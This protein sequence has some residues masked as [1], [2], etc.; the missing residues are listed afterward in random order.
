M[1]TWF[2][3]TIFVVSGLQDLMYDVGAYALS[4]YRRFVFGDRERLTTEK[5]R[6]REEQRL[7]VM[8]P[9]WNEG[10][11]V[12][13]MVANI[14]DRV[15]YRNYVIFVGT[16]PNDAA[17]QSA[18]DALAVKHKQLIKVVNPR[19]GPTCKA[20]CLN[21]VYETIK[22]YERMHG[23]NFDMIA[24]HDAEDVVHPYGF[25]LYNYLIP[26]VDAI[27]LPI[28]PLPTD[29][30][31]F[32]HWVYADEFCENH[33]KDVPVREKIS[34]F[35]PFAGVGT[36]FSRRVF[37]ALEQISG[38]EIFNEKSMAEDYSMSKKL[39]LMGLKTIFVNLV[40]ADDKSPWWTPLYK[41]PGF[42]SNWAFFPF[43]FTRSVR[44][45][46]RWIIGISL[47]EWEHS[48]WGP[49]PKMYES[50]VKDRKVFAAMSAS[51][52]GYFVL[53]YMLVA[54]ASYHGL[55]PFQLLPVVSPGSPVNYLLG[56]A[57]CIMTVR[58]IQ[59]W[60]IISRVYGVTAGTLSLV[61]I[62]VSNVI[63]GLAA[64]RALQAFARER[65]GKT[66]VKWDKTQHVE[67]VGSLPTDPAGMGE[68]KKVREELP[69]DRLLAMLKSGERRD[70][71]TALNSIPRNLPAQQRA[72][73][74]AEMTKLSDSDDTQVRATVA[75]SLGFVN[76]AESVSLMEHL[77]KDRQW[78]VRANSI[79]ALF[80]Q[81]NVMPQIER[82]LSSG[83]KFAIEVITRTVEQDRL[84]RAAVF[85]H[86]DAN[87][88]CAVFGSLIKESTILEWLYADWRVAGEKTPPLPTA[89][90]K[91][92]PPAADLPIDRKHAA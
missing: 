43:D 57:A 38:H 30:R 79:K 48:G 36:G 54:L 21:N 76:W 22:V 83:D 52:I 19:P 59:R 88:G 37:H 10:D 27:Q 26:R 3:A 71:L 51:F 23:V 42:I 44:Q 9:A 1:L 29:H 41:R 4:L 85:A 12:A 15:E 8:V 75:K 31:R 11:V 69:F 73:I 20:D 90:P 70:I 63:N 7:A 64:F 18:V 28:L 46:T 50:L 58:L 33:M 62:P 55:L 34:G 74:L 35:V 80:K 49:D 39:R 89:I 91:L 66:P 17:T 5:L 87:P 13:T 2:S 84:A 68:S 61:R 86:A 72:V 47:Q 82:L 56:V 25:A 16:Y 67:G 81:P 60:V 6:S 45:K 65:Q 77:V 14:I 92:T 32:V 78:I 53:L 40:L 24:M